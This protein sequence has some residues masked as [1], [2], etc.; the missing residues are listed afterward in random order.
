MNGILKTNQRTRTLA[1][2]AVM[3]ALSTVLSL[4]RLWEAPLGGSVTLFSMVPIIA[5]S[6][7]RGVKP[8]LASAFACS[9]IQLLL[10]LGNVA[11]IPDPL[12]IVLCVVFDYLVPFTL[13]GL[14][15][16]LSK[17]L[18]N[19]T[20]SVL[21]GTLLVCLFRFACHVFV[22]GVVWYSLTKA[23]GWNDTVFR[24]GMWT[25]SAIYNAA[26]FVPET[27]LTLI[28]AP[29]VGSVGKRVVK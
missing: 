23:G 22:G 20:V 12:G 2:C 17:P 19:R 18:R 24:Y 11:Y 21:A 16:A 6:Y 13:L 5:L 4:I 7:L 27:A 25:Y 15:A 26:F 1:E 14:A 8:A 28:G 10:G 9:V 29:V 3:V